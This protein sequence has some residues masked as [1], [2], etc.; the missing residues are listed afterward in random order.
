MKNLLKIVICMLSSVLFSV[1]LCYAQEDSQPGE[2][3]AGNIVDPVENSGG[4]S[5]VL[6]DNRNGLPTSEANDIE[7]T[8][9]GFIWI[10]S[11]G[12][13]I[14]YDGCS[15][16]RIDSTQGI[17][18]V[19]SLYADSEDRLWIGTNDNGLALM[20]KGF[21]R[22]WKTADG[23]HTSHASL[24]LKADCELVAVSRGYTIGADAN[25]STFCTTS[26]VPAWNGVKRLS[27]SENAIIALTE[28]G[29]VLAHAFGRNNHASF[30]F[31]QPVLAAAA[32][33]NHYAYLLADGTL[34]IRHADGRIETN[35]LK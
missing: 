5:A 13:L 34:E 32:A 16:E 27:A 15:F 10:G 18:S 21:F 20:G 6:Y 22:M 28:D 35:E 4:Y 9:D 2:A 14:R 8:E 12:G 24:A 11:Y 17:T 26:L 7:E 19:V 29:S 3:A 23:L 1:Q 30:A 33:P 25:G 31:D